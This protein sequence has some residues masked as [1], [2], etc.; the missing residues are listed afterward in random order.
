MVG[1]RGGRPD[2]Y[3]DGRLEEAYPYADENSGM[4]THQ[5]AWGISTHFQWMVFGSEQSVNATNAS[6]IY[7]FHPQGATVSFVDGSIHFMSTDTDNTVL[8]AMATRA[9]NESFDD[10]RIP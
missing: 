10:P 4:D 7:G 3:L 2:V 9:G 1:E 6:G 8:N 5:T